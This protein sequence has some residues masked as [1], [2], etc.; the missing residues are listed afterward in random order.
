MVFLTMCKLGE[1]IPLAA[2]I[3]A[4]LIKHTWFYNYFV[5]IEFDST[6]QNPNWHKDT[7]IFILII[8][9]FHAYIQW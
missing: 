2:G 5:V 1:A 3:C 6:H 8:P 9:Q 4:A 7:P